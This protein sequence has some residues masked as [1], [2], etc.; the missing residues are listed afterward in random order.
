MTLILVNHKYIDS[1]L[2]ITNYTHGYEERI[3]NNIIGYAFASNEGE[4]ESN[5]HSFMSLV[6]VYKGASKYAEYVCLLN[7][8]KHT[9]LEAYDSIAY[10]LV[11]KDVSRV[12]NYIYIELEDLEEVF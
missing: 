10:K 9:L 1:A 5:M 7:N 11:V 4:K 3:W 12:G 6:S 2:W 8:I